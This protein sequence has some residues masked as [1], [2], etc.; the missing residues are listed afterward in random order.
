MHF[1]P[2]G[3]VIC[4]AIAQLN[5]M[6]MPASLTSIRTHV[7]ENCSQVG[8]SLTIIVNELIPDASVELGFNIIIKSC[9]KCEIVNTLEFS[10]IEHKIKIQR[11]YINNIK[12]NLKKLSDFRWPLLASK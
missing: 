2:L 12:F 11:I 1:V 9:S 3:D 7:I 4:D 5:R 8:V 6:G 10:H